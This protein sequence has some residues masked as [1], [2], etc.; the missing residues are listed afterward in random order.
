MFTKHA[1]PANGNVH[2]TPTGCCERDSW[3]ADEGVDG[4]MLL[5][6]FATTIPAPLQVPGACLVGA[7]EG[8][9]FP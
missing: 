5:S 9:K 8:G 6:G 3:L 2:L 4:K 1:S 7:C